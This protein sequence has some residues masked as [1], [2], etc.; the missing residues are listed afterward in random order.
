MD[1]DIRIVG[2][3][4]VDGTGADRRRADVG[5]KDGRIVAVGDCPGTAARTIDA[6]GAIVTP[7]WVDIHTHY[8]GQ[9]S[10]DD[11]LAPSCFHGVTTVVMGS[12][13]V[14]FAPVRPTDRQRLVQLMEGVEDI[15]GTA[16]SEGIRWE[17][18][19]F[20]EYM[21][22]L[23][24]VPHAIDF[25]CMV[26]HDPL[27]V[28]AMGER[29][30][31]EEQATDEDVATMRALLREAVAAGAAGFST[32]RTDNHRDSD[33]KHT[34]SA[35]AA[36]R[37]LTGLAS[38]LVGLDHG[39]LQAVSDFDMVESADRFDGEFD[40]L[41]K[42]AQAAPGHSLSLSLLQRIRAPQ[43]WQQI[44]KRVDA[45]V[46]GGLDVRVQVGA[47][48]IGVLLGL[49]ATFHPFIGFPSYRAIAK[50]P[51]AERV[52]RMREPE[53]KAQL[54]SEE[55]GKVSGDGSSIPPLVD[56][57]LA[58]I[59]MVA[60]R[61]YRLGDPVDYE[62]PPEASL[63]AEAR[64]KGEPVLSV[65]YDALLGDE[66]RTLLYFPIYNYLGGNLDVVHTMLNHP[67]ALPGL[68]DGGAHVGTICDASFPTTML[69]HWARDR[70]KGLPL[71][72]VVKMMT[73]DTARYIGMNDRGTLTPGAK[74]DVNV[75]DL[76]NLTLRRPHLVADLP[77]GGKR[78]L[79]NAE[80]YRVTLVN[81]EQIIDND[82]LTSAR[83]GRLVRLG[84]RASA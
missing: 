72:K 58:Q 25:A 80:G 13:G 42:M 70:A 8:D 52:A 6:A 38:A 43:Q 76:E 16:L 69:T 74:A 26:P 65:I 27:R 17:W 46:A 49:D 79:Q 84:A 50:L 20:P 47:R 4:V 53:F 36:E 63:A 29:A 19:S 2:G 11:T 35:E 3:T 5:I 37:E 77:A 10:W 60:T 31:A 41:E 9:V 55:S 59:D 54:L 34:P 39:V 44:L 32:G 62:P 21:D 71:E 30:I 75:I 67:Q 83:P 51:L 68:S 61:T 40:L 82:T 12:C 24:K 56:L 57:L 23:E 66:G 14:G 15:P 78:L 73:H 64:A 28:Y 22:A 48:G 18:E 45:A 1:Y 81:G 7:G 33:G